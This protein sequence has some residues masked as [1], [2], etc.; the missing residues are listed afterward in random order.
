MC[1]KLS[2]RIGSGA[3]NGIDAPITRLA[4]FLENPMEKPLFLDAVL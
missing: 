4:D 2:Q 1:Q 3:P